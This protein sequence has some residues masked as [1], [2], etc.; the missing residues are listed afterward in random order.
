MITNV[1]MVEGKNLKTIYSFYLMFDNFFF[2]VRCKKA[3]ESYV[4]DCQPGYEADDCS[5]NINE[6]LSN[7]CKN[8][9][10]CIDG[11]A[12]YTCQCKAGWIGTL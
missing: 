6:C 3:T 1:K 7:Q 8:S 5:A 9:A 4:C 12:N 10:E 11:I 2:F